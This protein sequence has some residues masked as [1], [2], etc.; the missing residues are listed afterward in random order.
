MGGSALFDDESLRSI[1]NPH[2]LMLRSFPERPDLLCRSTSRTKSKMAKMA[3]SGTKVPDWS[4]VGTCLTCS[5]GYP[6]GVATRK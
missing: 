1:A 4:H 2:A 5:D 3:T 6:E